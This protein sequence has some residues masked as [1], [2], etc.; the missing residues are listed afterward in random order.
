MLY[1]EETRLAVS[2]YIQIWQVSARYDKVS[3]TSIVDRNL[4]PMGARFAQNGKKFLADKRDW[5]AITYLRR[6]KIRMS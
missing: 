5:S 2:P 6:E 3:R 4:S 1:N